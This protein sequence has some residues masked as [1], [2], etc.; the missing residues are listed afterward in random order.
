[1]PRSPGATLLVEEGLAEESVAVTAAFAE[2]L[3][4][5]GGTIRGAGERALH[6]T[7]LASAAM[8]TLPM[9]IRRRF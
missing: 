7:T 4:Q 6:P 5:A 1:M 8:V 9:R 2:E 3:A